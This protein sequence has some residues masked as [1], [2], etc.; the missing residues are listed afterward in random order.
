MNIKRK[1]IP[2]PL[3]SE[4]FKAR[5]QLRNELKEA[6]AELTKLDLRDELSLTIC[7]MANNPGEYIKDHPEEKIRCIA[8]LANYALAEIVASLHTDKCAEQN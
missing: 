7:D 3:S 6:V 5:A 2:D 4:G 8:V 1:N